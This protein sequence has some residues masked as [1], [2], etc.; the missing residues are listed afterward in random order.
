VNYVFQFETLVREWPLLLDGLLLT[1]RLSVIAMIIGLAV[2]T[3]GFMEHNFYAVL[4]AVILNLFV[5]LLLLFNF[6]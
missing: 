5:I 4:C 3:A 1:M 2:G 6:L